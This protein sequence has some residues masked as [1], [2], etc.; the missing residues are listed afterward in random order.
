MAAVRVS[1][2]PMMTVSLAEGVAAR[3]LGA[4]S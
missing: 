2:I 4:G 1:A 3:L